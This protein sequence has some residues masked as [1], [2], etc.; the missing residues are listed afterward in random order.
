ME[1]EAL[2]EPFVTLGDRGGLSR[3]LLAEVVGA[4][5]VPLR[6]VALKL[7]SDEYPFLPEGV[8][9]GFTNDD[10]EASWT[11]SRDARALRPGGGGHPGSGRG[12]RPAG[13]EPAV[14][15]PTFYCKRRRAFFAAPCPAC[16][17]PLTDVRDDRLLESLALP[18]RDRSLVRSWPARRRPRT[19][20]D[21]HP[22]AGDRAG[23]RDRR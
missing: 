12:T 3:V 5:D 9:V 10:V 1:P 18:R 20:V 14:L 16:G 23:G 8:G 21:A 6:A 17:G 2:A 11:R 7:Q 4:R 13:R 19:P 15:P 22:R